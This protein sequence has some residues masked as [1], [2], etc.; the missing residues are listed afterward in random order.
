MSIGAVNNS[1]FG[2]INNLN[3]SNNL[4]SSAMQKISSGFKINKGS[5]NPSGLVISE[6]LRS[7]LHGTQRAIQNNQ[8]TSNMLGIAEGGMA[9]MSSMLTKAKSLTIAS[10]NTGV[11]TGGQVNANQAELNGILQSFQNIAST[12][13]YSSKNLL[14]GS[15]GL[16][17]NTASNM[18]NMNTSRIPVVNAG[19]AQFKFDGNVTNQAERANVSANAAEINVAPVSTLANAQEFTVSG[20]NGSQEFSF[21]AGDSLND[22]ISQINDASSSTGVTAYGIRDAADN[23]VGVRL[24]SNEYGSS[25]SVTVEQ[26][27]GDLFATAGTTTTDAGQDLTV[28]VNGQT[29]TGDGLNVSVN[30]QFSG[31]LRFNESVAQTGYDQATLTNAGA[32]SMELRGGMQFQLGESGGTENLGIQDMSL[33]NLG[34]VTVGDKTYSMA[35]LFSGGSASLSSNPEIAAKVIEQAIKDVS[36]ARADIGAYQ[37]NMLQTNSNS[38][39]I[40]ME[41]ITATES[42]IRDTDVAKSMTEQTKAMILGKTGIFSIQS[43]NKNASFYTQLLGNNK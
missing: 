12:T 5:D 13:R 38:L 3:K 33:H 29:I 17:S 28:S 19:A 8:E 43:A 14:N 34:K 41:N 36:G 20:A 9:G 30:G 23:I 10:L 35:D 6:L 16:Q 1:T 4:A 42:Y 2:F 40:A 15:G 37:T 18:L 39:A 26:E 24:A 22:V 27:T 21:A 31:D 32:T 11:T 25:Q 7:Q